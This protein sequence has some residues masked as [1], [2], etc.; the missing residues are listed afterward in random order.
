MSPRYL[1]FRQEIFLPNLIFGFFLP[2]Q[3]GQKEEAD[4]KHQF[5]PNDEST[6]TKGEYKKMLLIA[7]KQI[8]NLQ[9]QVSSYTFENYTMADAN[10]WY[11]KSLIVL[12][13]DNTKKIFA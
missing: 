6:W 5:D 3:T 9:N 12:L 1:R 13:Q 2:W 10:R 7:K 8:C 11:Q 4:P